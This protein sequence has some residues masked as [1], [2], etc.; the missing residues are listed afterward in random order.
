MEFSVEKWNELC[1]E[2]DQLEDDFFSRFSCV[3]ESLTSEKMKSS[4]CTKVILGEWVL[5]FAK[6]YHRTKVLT[7][8]SASK[9]EGLNA[10]VIEKQEKVINLQE[11]LLKSRDDQLSAVQTTVRNEL[12]SVQT[13]VKA[14]I[15]SWSEVVK[16]NTS[17]PIT[18]ASLKEAVKSAV[19]EEDRTRNIMIFGKE[20]V[21]NEDLSQTVSEI[22]EDLGEK[23]HTIEFRRVGTARTGKCR[24]IKVKLSSAEAVA[25]VLRRARALKSSEKHRS[26]YLVADRNQEERDFFKKLVDQMKLKIKR[27]P[28]MYHFIKGGQITSVRRSGNGSH[29]TNSLTFKLLLSL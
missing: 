22:F 2:M 26:T 25:H 21:V 9:I 6:M 7:V 12:A 20:D 4:T 11:E 1:L 15:G 5:R 17:P 10:N 14:E 24:P 13:V 8:S 27:E 28:E 3:P 19:S 18:P 16:R 23:P 29:T